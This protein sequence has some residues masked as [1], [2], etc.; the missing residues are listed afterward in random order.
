VHVVHLSSWH[1]LPVIRDARRRGV[2][3][4]VETC[5]HY[6][7]FAAEE[8]PDGATELKCAPPIR[9]AEHREA[10]WDALGRGEI[11]LI[12]SDHSPCPPALKRPAPAGDDFFAAWGGIASLQLS[13]PA[14]WEGAR[15]RGFRVERLVEWMSAAPAR[16][17]GLETAKGRLAAGYD[18][19]LVV[20]DP[21]AAFVVGDRP[22]YHRHPLTPYRGRTLHGVVHATYVAGRAAF[23]DGT[24]ASSPAGELLR[25]AHR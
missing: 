8:I 21:D 14:V 19:D 22:L 9:T 13:L 7:T 3:L 1:S 17:A 10:L 24:F 2:R 11:D 15:A 5:P 12:V 18:A 23:A 6:L 4:S 20:W 25:P 16:L